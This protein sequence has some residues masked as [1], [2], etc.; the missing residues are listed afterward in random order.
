MRL[1]FLGAA[2]QVTGSK[3]WLQTPAGNVLVDCGLYQGQEHPRVQNNLDLNIGPADI[4]WVLLTHA[5]IDHS[6]LIPR[7][8]KLGFRGQVVTTAATADLCELMLLDSAH[9]QEEDAKFDLK[10]WRRYG[11]PGPPPQ[12]LHT[13][14]DV[15]QCLQT[16]QPVAYDEKIQLAPGLVVRF[17]DAG[18]ILGS[19]SIEVWLTE[20]DQEHKIVFSGDIGSPNRPILRDPQPP[21]EADFVVIESTSGDRRHKPRAESV[22]RLRNII[23]TTIKRR[24][25][26]LIPAFAVGRTQEVLFELADFIRA[27]DIPQIPV[28]VDSPMAVEATEIFRRHP[29]CFDQEMNQLIQS[30]QSPFRFP[31]L[32]IVRTRE[33]SM[34][35]NDFRK[36]CIIISASG[37]CTGGRIRHHLRHHLGHRQ[38]TLLFVGYQAAGTLGR[39]ILDGAKRVQIFPRETHRVRCKVESLDGFSAHADQ[40]GLLAWLERVASNTPDVFVVHGEEQA[41]FALSKAIVDRLGLRVHVPEVFDSYDLLDTV[42]LQTRAFHSPAIT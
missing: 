1:S 6:G 25:H 13:V 42:S 15:Q 34:R 19:A 10:K 4:K 22:T 35:I 41:A 18:H 5:H 16:F 40:A 2:R 28:F 9:I 8:Y 31:G 23:R 24:G 21:P 11:R 32:Q 26:V 7:L 33:E 30:D 14:Q 20:G 12:P 38:D 39:E 17:R 29:E 37:M 36:P 3:F 27:G